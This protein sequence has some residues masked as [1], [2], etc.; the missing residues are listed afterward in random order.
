MISKRIKELAAIIPSANRVIDVGCDHALLDIYLA[1]KYPDTKFLATDISEN[2]INS[3]LKNIKENNLE[4]RISTSVTDGLDNISLN[5]DDFIVISG[6]GTNTIKHILKPRLNEINN[7]LI[8]TNRDFEELR[9]FMFENGFRTKDE[10][11]IH[12]KLYYVVMLFEKGEFKYTSLDL[13]L[14]PIIKNSK[15]DSYFEFLLKNYKK[16]LPGIP[17][18]DLKKN[19]VMEKI[20]VLSSLIEKK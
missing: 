14:G 4:S 18:N 11:I 3:A 9:E 19:E 1:K 12:D 10:K 15:N 7:I 8:Q 16:I 13:W 20:N 17:D 5:K 6:M 2:A